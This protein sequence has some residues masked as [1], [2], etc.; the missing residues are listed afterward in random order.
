METIIKKMNEI[1]EHGK[2]VEHLEELTST[3][4]NC[5]GHVRSESQGG[6]AKDMKKLPRT[7]EDC[8]GH[9]KIAEN[10]DNCCPGRGNNNQEDGRN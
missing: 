3:W 10:M 9:G 2:N 1:E 7:L 8:Q 5:K 4:Q 6:T